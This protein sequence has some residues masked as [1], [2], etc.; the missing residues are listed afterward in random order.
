MLL[1]T[2]REHILSFHELRSE[3]V[4]SSQRETNV[5]FKGIHQSKG[6]ATFQKALLQGTIV[7]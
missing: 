2:E 1:T 6:N 5:N 7:T 4:S 3:M